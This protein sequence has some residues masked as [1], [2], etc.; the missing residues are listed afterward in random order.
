MAPCRTSCDACTQPSAVA[1]NLGALK[2][3]EL[4]RS[5]PRRGFGRG[6]GGGGGD[7]GFGRYAPQLSSGDPGDGDGNGKNFGEQGQGGDGDDDEQP[8]LV[9]ECSSGWL[10][11]QLPS[12]QC[13]RLSTSVSVG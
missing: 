7:F 10:F 12:G 6:F 4:L 9:C 13:H 1:D 2:K 11:S 5:G 8:R 3:Q